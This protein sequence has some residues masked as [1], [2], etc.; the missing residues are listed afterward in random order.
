MMM[1]VSKQG[2]FPLEEEENKP[3]TWINWRCQNL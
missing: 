1:H 3:S 2:P